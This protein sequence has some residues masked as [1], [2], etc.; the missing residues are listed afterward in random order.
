MALALYDW[1]PNTAGEDFM[2]DGI[3]QQMD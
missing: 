1:M 3:N 2:F